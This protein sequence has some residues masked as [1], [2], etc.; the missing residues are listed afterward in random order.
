MPFYKLIVAYDGSRFNGSQRQITNADMQQRLHKQ[1]QQQ[2]QQ[3]PPQQPAGEGEQGGGSPLPHLPSSQALPRRSSRHLVPKRPH[4]ESNG[5]KKGT[6]S[7][8]QDCLEDAIGLWT[9]QSVN[10]IGL[11]FAGRT[12]KGVHARGQVAVVRLPQTYEGWEI[13]N[14]VNSRLPYDISVVEAH[15]VALDDD[16]NDAAEA[17]EEEQRIG[18]DDAP[19]RAAVLDPRRDAVAKQYSYTIKFRRLV[20]DPVTGQPLPVCTR[21]GPHAIRHGLNDGPCLWVIPWCL[22]DARF[23]HLCQ[24]L[25]GRHDFVAFVH[26]H[27]RDTSGNGAD[28]LTLDRM[29]YEVLSEVKDNVSGG[30]GGK[31]DGASV[32]TARFVLEAQGFRRTLVRNLVGFCVDV[33]RNRV[34]PSQLDWDRDLWTVEAAAHVH[35]APACGLCLEWV[36]Y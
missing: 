8:V 32:V 14:H 35:A 28:V 9:C 20:L 26:K 11:K 17:E 31:C 21:A 24:V 25:Q 36:R 29:D 27:N 12:D 19:I 13:L 7:T 23:Q 34:G 4:W 5:Q 30:G 15:F 10:D 33:G 1:Q 16:D 22:D 2:Q 6:A 18:S 3:Q